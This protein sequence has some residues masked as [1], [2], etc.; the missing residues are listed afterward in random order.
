MEILTLF[1]Y[2]RVNRDQ[3]MDHEAWLKTHQNVSNFETA[4]C[5]TIQWF[6]WYLNQSGCTTEL[7]KQIKK[8]CY[9]ALLIHKLLTYLTLFTFGFGVA[10]VANIWEYSISRHWMKDYFWTLRYYLWFEGGLVALEQTQKALL[11]S[12]VYCV[13][14]AKWTQQLNGRLADSYLLRKE[15]STAKQFRG[16]VQKCPSFY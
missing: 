15:R 5:L 1:K 2:P 3:V 11:H 14:F 9:E 8:G 13:I 12:G 7:G 4:S 10:Y 16:Y 6:L